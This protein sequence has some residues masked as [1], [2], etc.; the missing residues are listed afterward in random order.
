MWFVYLA[1]IAST[2]LRKKGVSLETITVGMRQDA[3]KYPFLIILVSNH[4]Q[5]TNGGKILVVEDPTE[6]GLA[7]MREFWASIG[8][9]MDHSY[10]GYLILCDHCC[11][12]Y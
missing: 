2:A 3:E 5:V 7:I 6:Q 8:C 1:G 10:S 9:H 12:N 4:Y 11:C